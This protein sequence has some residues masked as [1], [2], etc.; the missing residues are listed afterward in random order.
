MEEH[1]ILAEKNR[2]AQTQRLSHSRLRFN[3][4][5]GETEM[6]LPPGLASTRRTVPAPT[7]RRQRQA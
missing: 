1:I 3:D 4:E 5:N 7:L 6:N 2:A